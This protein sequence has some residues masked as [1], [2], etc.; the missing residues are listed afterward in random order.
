MKRDGQESLEGIPAG[1]PDAFG[2]GDQAGP[3]I[4]SIGFPS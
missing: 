3:I 4:L 1:D 2:L